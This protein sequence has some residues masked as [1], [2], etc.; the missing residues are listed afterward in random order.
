MDKK[1]GLIFFFSSRRRHTRLRRDWSSDVCYSDLAPPHHTRGR[2]RISVHEDTDGDGKYDRHKVFLDGLDLANAA[3]PGKGGIWVMHTPYLLFYPDKDRD[4][5]PD[6]DPEV[7]L[8]GFGFADTHSVANG[9]VCGPDGWIS[10]GQ[11]APVPARGWRPW[12]DPEY[13]PPSPS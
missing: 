7:H 5:V 2:S 9:L 8:A 6:G 13:T 12:S 3:L 4:D 1:C 11:G 10:G